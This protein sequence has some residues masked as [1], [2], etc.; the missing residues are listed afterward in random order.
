MRACMCVRY[1]RVSGK[2]KVR[3]EE[4]GKEKEEEEKEKEERGLVAHHSPR[5]GPA[6]PQRS[7]LP[8][9]PACEAEG[10]ETSSPG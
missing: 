10:E 1:V 7:T 9:P 8:F 5:T 4:R 3:V 2:E 6:Q